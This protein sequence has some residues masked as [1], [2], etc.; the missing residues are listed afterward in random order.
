M[1]WKEV[2]KPKFSQP[3]PQQNG[4]WNLSPSYVYFLDPGL[5]G[6]YVRLFTGKTVLELGAGTGCYS[7]AMIASGKVRRVTAVE[8]ALNIA[9]ITHGAITSADLTKELRFEP[10]DWVVSTEV[11]EHIPHNFMNI[12]LENLVRH[13]KEG[14]VLSW[15]IRGQGGNGHV[16]CLNNDEVE[17]ELRRYGFTIDQDETRRIRERVTS[18][19]YKNT[20]MIFRPDHR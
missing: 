5:V 14:L 2:P 1:R 6:E 8:G 3:K 17:D 20:L 11:G 12:Y 9:N 19:Q 15:A 13:A 7:K 4:A 18:N 16:N 10:A